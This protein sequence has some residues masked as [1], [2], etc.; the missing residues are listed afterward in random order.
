MLDHFDHSIAFTDRGPALPWND[1]VYVGRYFGLIRQIGTNKNNACIRLGGTKN[2]FN[3]HTG[4][5]STTFEASSFLNGT[6]PDCMTLVRVAHD[7]CRILPGVH[8]DQ[9]QFD[10]FDSNRSYQLIMEGF[11]EHTP[12]RPDDILVVGPR[13]RAFYEEVL[14]L[15]LLEKIHNLD[16]Y[17]PVRYQLP[18]AGVVAG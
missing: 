8:L 11:M 15:P 5:V 1:K 17:T 12:P 14:D 2:E 16:S 6:L 13:W 7:A 10:L 9:N 4:Q 3:V 18:R